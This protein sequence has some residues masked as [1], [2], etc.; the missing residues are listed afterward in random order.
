MSE[1]S[2]L[3]KTVSEIL[4]YLTPRERYVLEQ[5]YGYRGEP[6]KQTDLAAEFNISRTRVGQIENNALRKI[7]QPYP[8]IKM[9]QE[10]LPT[11]LSRE[12]DDFY[13]LFFIK[14]FRLKPEHIHHILQVESSKETPEQVPEEITSSSS[15]ESLELSI[16][17]FG[18]LTRAG[19]YT[20]QDLMALSDTKLSK[21]KDLNKKSLTEIR[22][23]LLRLT[24]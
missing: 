3:E 10:Y 15:I 9:L 24:K 7:R 21:I 12:K 23:K 6:V 14:L 5:R 22:E 16:R 1:Q 8:Q 18:A 2:N 17:T 19:V 11:V 4:E 13:F 20:I